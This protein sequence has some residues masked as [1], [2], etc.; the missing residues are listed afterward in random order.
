MEEEIREGEKEGDGVEGLIINH[1]TF[2]NF[3]LTFESKMSII[4]IINVINVHLSRK[5]NS[6]LEE[7][8]RRW[9][10][11][12]TVSAEDQ[13]D[14]E[15]DADTP[16]SIF[17]TRPSVSPLNSPR[18]SVDGEDDSS[19]PVTVNFDFSRPST[20]LG[21]FSRPTDL[22][23]DPSTTHSSEL[24]SPSVLVSK[25]PSHSVSPQGLTSKIR[26]IMRPEIVI[27]D[28]GEGLDDV[29]MTFEKNTQTAFNEVNNDR[30][31]A[32]NIENH[33]QEKHVKQLSNKISWLEKELEIWRSGEA[34][35]V[36]DQIDLAVEALEANYV[37]DPDVGCL[38]PV[39]EIVVQG[40]EIIKHWLVTGLSW[41]LA[42]VNKLAN[43][44]ARATHHQAH[45]QAGYNT[46]VDM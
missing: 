10:A 29:K 22:L 15:G 9:R 20:L 12:D 4:V 18:Q 41:T 19:R 5:K 14:L 38:P 37:H 25:T 23:D 44:I 34:V 31:I 42:G 27:D 13:L 6:M 28:D 2:T 40:Y 8:V 45:H 32:N 3:L 39:T 16:Q 36:E 35:P 17:R 7:E 46:F 26:G 21:E 11:G 30:S 1:I 33:S 24:H 43:Y